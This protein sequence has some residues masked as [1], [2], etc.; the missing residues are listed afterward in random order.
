[1]GRMGRC[2]AQGEKPARAACGIVGT[3]LLLAGCGAGTN[4]TPSAAANGKYYAV[5]AET[6]SFFRYGPQQG[7]GP[8]MELPKDTLMTLI[9]PSFGYSKVKLFKAG[10]Q[11]FVASEDIHA[12]PKSLV[13]EATAPPPGS[14]PS[15]K[16]RERGEYFDLHSNDPRLIPPPEKLPDPDLPPSS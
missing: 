10:E 4:P 11:G 14:T 7:N 6:T 13:E 9:R 16:R 12:A 15:P 8:D 5:T 1:M 2:R 3:L